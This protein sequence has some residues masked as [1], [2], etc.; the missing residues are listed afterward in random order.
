MRSKYVDVCID[1]DRVR[2]AAE[3]IRAATAVRLIAVIKADAYGCG[4]VAVAD[5]LASVADEFAYF[6]SHEARD[7]KRP[8]IVLGPPEGDPDQYRELSVRP[9]VATPAEAK[10]Y[11]SLRPL[12]NVDSGMQ[13]FGCNPTDVDD[14]LTS[15]RFAEAFTHT[16]EPR[17]AALLRKLCGGRVGVIHAANTALLDCPAAWLDA[18]RPGLGLYQGAVRVATRLAAVRETSGGIGYGGIDVPRVGVILAGYSNQLQPGPVL[19]NGR[20]QGV[21][22][23]GMNSAY[24]SITA[25]ERVGDEVVLLGDGLTEAELAAHFGVPPHAILCRYTALGRRRWLPAVETGTCV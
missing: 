1:L 16:T 23:V 9:A 3:R 5:A 24:V 19:I 15:H 14:L 25:S 2:A 11:G 6:S 10:R 8:G 17:G 20:R 22:E 12:L 4:A 21:L 13:R 18:V 7:V